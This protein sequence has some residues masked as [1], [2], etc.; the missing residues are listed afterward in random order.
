MSASSAAIVIEN[1]KYAY[2]KNVEAVHDLTMT[3]Q[4]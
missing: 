4:P 2:R 3:V 1:L